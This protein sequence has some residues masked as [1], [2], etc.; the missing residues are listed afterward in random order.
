MD[1]KS[2][3]MVRNFKYLYGKAFVKDIKNVD[4]S[5]TIFSETE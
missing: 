1:T 5:V 3:K 2:T 4:W